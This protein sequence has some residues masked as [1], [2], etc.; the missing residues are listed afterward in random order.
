MNIM[1][2]VI[3]RSKLNYITNSFPNKSKNILRGFYFYS[4]IDFIQ[5]IRTYKCQIRSYLLARTLVF[6]F[7]SSYQPIQVFFFLY[8]N[9][10]FC[11]VNALGRIAKRMKRCQ[12]KSK[13]QVSCT[14]MRYTI[15]RIC[16]I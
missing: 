1:N 4:K 5:L 15:H 12:K 13:K 3:H 2:E 7:F 6:F 14:C 10:L 11:S 8:Y 16:I 9:C